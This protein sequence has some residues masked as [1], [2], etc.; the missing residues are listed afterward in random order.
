MSRN[1]FPDPIRL[2]H[3]PVSFSGLLMKAWDGVW[4][5]GEDLPSFDF[6]PSRE[7]TTHRVRKRG[8]RGRQGEGEEILSEINSR[9]RLALQPSY[10]PSVK[11]RRN[12]F[13]DLRIATR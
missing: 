12:K 9:R 10:G 1:F 4:H 13:L 8:K 11:V 2:D 6:C 7:C 3:S 5:L